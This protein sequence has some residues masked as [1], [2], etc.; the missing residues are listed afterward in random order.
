MV[1][2]LDAKALKFRKTDERNHDTLT[3]CH[4]PVRPERK[5]YFRESNESWRCSCGTIRW[6]CSTTLGSASKQSFS[7][8]P[9]RYIV[10]VVVKD[11]EGHTTAARNTGIEV[12]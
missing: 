1:A 4:G 6:R 3:R 2:R 12:P 7:A 9:G 5:L 8:T 10:R 11:S